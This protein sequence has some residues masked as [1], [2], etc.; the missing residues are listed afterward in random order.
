MGME[1]PTIET[2]R[3]RLVPPAS[4]HFDAFAAVLADR[5]FVEHLEIEPCSRQD[6]HRS[7]CAMLGHWQLLGWGGF[8]VED[9]ETGAFVGRVGVSNWEGW[10]E[11]ELGWWVVPT[12]WGRGYAV[13][14]ARA[15]LD[16]VRRLRRTSR[17]ASFVRSENT[18]SIRVAEKLGG[19]YEGDIDLLGRPARV[20][21]YTL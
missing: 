19:V 6:A 1:I 7:F 16:F 2:E 5:R 12:A 21:G 17:L 18:R 14:S 15:V 3:L 8:I 13:E 10:P 20:Y 11:A 4:R 9:R